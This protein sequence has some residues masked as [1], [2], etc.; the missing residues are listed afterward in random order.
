MANYT[1]ATDFQA[2]DAL[3][4]GNP[5]KI[6]KGTELND[7]FNAIQTAVATKADLA[8]PAFTGNPTAATQTAGNSST[9]LATTSFVGTA[10]TNGLA[11]LG[12]MATQNANAVAITGGS[13]TGLTALTIPSAAI[14][15]TQAVGDSSLAVATTAFV[16]A[17]I[18]N[19]ISNS[20]TGAN[21]SLAESG[22]QKLPGGLILQ[23]G[24]TADL[25]NNDVI[26]VTFPTAFSTACYQV[27]TCIN[28]T[29]AI[30]QGTA[31]AHTGDYTT[32]NFKLAYDADVNPS[33][34]PV[35]WFAVGK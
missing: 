1:K 16:N 2:K 31:S 21:Q 10:V 28:R 14:A 3:L 11:T 32:T 35:V 20:F 27:T 29:S 9:R 12:T 26:T 5:A 30:S 24:K 6:I 15:T 8:S 25:D 7:E 13:I 19:D 22:F 17:E 23:W 4:T 18:S 33:T 34:N